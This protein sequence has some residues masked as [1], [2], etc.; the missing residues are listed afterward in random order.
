[1][2]HQMLIEE[3][4]RDRGSDELFTVPASATIG[5][6]VALMAEREIG[7]VLV[8][9]EDGLVAGIFT[10][11]D[12]LMRVVHAGLHTAGHA[13]LAGDDTQRA[14]RLAR[15]HGRGGDGA[16]ACQ[17][18][19]P[20]AGDRRPH[21]AW[22]GVD[23][24]PGLPDRAPRPAGLCRRGAEHGGFRHESHCPR[25]PGVPRS[26][27]GWVRSRCWPP[28]AAS[29]RASSPCRAAARR[30]STAWRWV[31]PTRSRS[32]GRRCRPRRWPR[33]SLPWRR[34]WATWSLACPTT[35]PTPRCRA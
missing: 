4:V 23:A 26:R 6:A 9:N 25:L 28:A 13:D 1:M 21:G 18:A 19:P 3:V 34:R 14:L 16:D 29:A 32:P 12:L 17:P 8:M 10:E 20:P 35:T 5:E 2:P 33:R 15:H 31:R 30:P 27:P 7:A 22:P 11:R 24:R